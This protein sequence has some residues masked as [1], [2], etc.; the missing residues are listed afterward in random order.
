M[1]CLGHRRQCH[2]LLEQLKAGNVHHGYLFCGP[3]H[4]GKFTVAR[5]F[6][7][8]CLGA[9]CSDRRLE[10]AHAVERNVHPDV[11]VLDQLWIDGVCTDWSEIARSSNVPQAHRADLRRRA[12]SD[13]IG[14]DD[15]RAL[16]DRL[17]VRPQGGL[18]FCLIRSLERLHLTA[19]H[20]LLHML[21]EPP[22]NVVFLCTTQVSDAI[23]STIR[24]RL[25]PLLFSPLPSTELLSFIPASLGYDRPFLLEFAQGAPGVVERCR[26][27]QQYLRRQKI[28]RG[29]SARLLDAHDPSERWKLLQSASE[30]LPD[31]LRHLLLEIRLRLRAHGGLTPPLRRT[32]RTCMNLLRAVGDNVHSEVALQYAALSL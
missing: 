4:I 30:E 9:G 19:G 1:Q 2:I 20:A 24:S 10:I 28:L 7:V 5:W 3:R 23:P 13:T 29:T 18:A 21:E 26:S 27:D 15:I 25:W 22:T 11:L 17:I 6:A 14:I 16:H 32:Y 31:L 12:K 8:E